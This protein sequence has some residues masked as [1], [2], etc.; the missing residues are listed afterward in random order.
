MQ[1]MSKEELV[2]R[3]VHALTGDLSAFFEICSSDCRVWHSADDK[4]MSVQAAVDAAKARGGLPPF[5]TPRVLM[6]ASGF[7]VQTATT[8]APVGKLHIVQVATVKDGKV[9]AVEEYISPEMQIP[10]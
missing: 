2:K 1:A 10:G 9:T 6:T 3:W 8:V 4:W 7:A 5:E